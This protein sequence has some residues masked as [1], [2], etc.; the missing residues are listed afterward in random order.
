MNR[1]WFSRAAVL[2]LAIAMLTSSCERATNAPELRPQATA[3]STSYTLVHDVLPLPV[4]NLN[5]SSLI[6]IGGGSISVLGHTLTV[7]SGAVTSPTLFTM[8][9][10]TD[11]DHQSR[12]FGDCDRPAGQHSQHGRHV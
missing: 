10:L 7:P 4:P 9:A 11:G 6:G 1:Y 5:V 2:A 3:T 8:I 12:R